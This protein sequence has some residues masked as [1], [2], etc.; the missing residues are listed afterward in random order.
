M[1]KFYCSNQTFDL[2]G[3]NLD[4]GAGCI[5]SNNFKSWSYVNENCSWTIDNCHSK[6]YKFKK[7]TE[8]GGGL[9]GQGIGNG[10]ANV[11]VIITNC[12]NELDIGTR[13][14][15]IC[16]QYASN[17]EIMYCSNYGDIVGDYAGGIFGASSYGGTIEY[18]WNEGEIGGTRGLVVYVDSEQVKITP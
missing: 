13:A 9:C 17:Y 15:G 6:I 1:I 12:T 14:G 10:S 16:G 8:S 2:Y 5:T 11:T 4:G 18:C 3:S 7:I